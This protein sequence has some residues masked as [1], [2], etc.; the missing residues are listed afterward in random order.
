MPTKVKFHLEQFN[1]AAKGKLND[2][3]MEFRFGELENKVGKVLFIDKEG[4]FVVASE[5]T[6]IRLATN[7][8]DS[9]FRVEEVNR[10]FQVALDDIRCV[11]GSVSSNNK[12]FLFRTDH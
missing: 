4:G 3:F 1:P 12:L 11:F 7:F 6:K 2:S 5:L 8:R 9:F 10:T